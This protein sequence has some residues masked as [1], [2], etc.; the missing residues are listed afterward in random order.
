V[1]TPNLT[2]EVVQT[3]AHSNQKGVASARLSRVGMLM[4]PPN[5]LDMPSTFGA[6]EGAFTLKRGG[7]VALRASSTVECG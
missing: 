2:W 5:A 7:G 6:S 4:G 1:K 3:N